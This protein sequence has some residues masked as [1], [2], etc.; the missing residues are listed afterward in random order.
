MRCFSARSLSFV[1]LAIFPAVAAVAEEDSKKPENAPE[2]AV[3]DLREISAFDKS[4]QASGYMLTRGEYAECKAEPFK[5]VKAYPPLKSKHPLYGT[6]KFGNDPLTP[7]KRNLEYHF[8][9]DESG[10]E[11]KVEKKAEKKPDAPLIKELKGILGVSPDK[12]ANGPLTNTP[13]SRYDRLYFDINHDLDLTNDPVLKPLANAPWGSL[14]PWSVEEKMAFDYL[15]LPFDYGPGVGMKP[16]R[17]LPWLSVSEK[18]KYTTMHFVAVA[19]RQG[20]IRI[21]DHFYVALLAQPYAI[22][23]RFDWPATTLQLRPVI[24]GDNLESWGFE[25]DSLMAMRQVDGELYVLTAS[26]LG[27]KVTVKPYR[28][29]FGVFKVGPGGRNIKPED[30]T[31]RGSLRS[32]TTAFGFGPQQSKPG[33]PEEKI[34]ECK[35]PVGDYLLSDL[36]ISYGKLHI[37]ISDNYHSDGKPRDSE[38]SRT[39]GIKIAKDKPFVLDFSNKPEILFASP[40]KE[41]TYK[42]GDEIKVAAVLIDPVLDI[43]IR[44]LDDTTRTKKETIKYGD[45][46]EVTNERPLSLDPLVT[47][48]NSA[49]KKVSEGVMPFG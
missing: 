33:E 1:F 20:Q 43:M 22:T 37:F 39:Y 41:Q 36:S 44:N 17:I 32:E 38:R 19:A 30:I 3:F 21:H 15:D 25:S 18:G 7:G 10:E 28:G 47:I 4:D 35:A 13:L 16:F 31:I 27:D 8:V 29:D 14:P 12:N 46:Q 42:L 45:G 26:P 2:E 23:G 34:K 48:T 40:A 9:L 24:P 5:E 49:G 6:V 11:P